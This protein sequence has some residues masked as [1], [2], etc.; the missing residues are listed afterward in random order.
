MECLLVDFLD[1]NRWSIGWGNPIISNDRLWNLN[2]FPPLIYRQH[3][4]PERFQNHFEETIENL[5]T[6]GKSIFLMRD[7][8]INL[9]H[10]SSCNYA[11]NFL[12]SLKSFN[13]I[14]TINKP[15][16][17]HNN[18]FSLIDNI[19]TNKLDGDMWPLTR[20]RTLTAS[21]FQTEIRS[22]AV[23]HPFSHIVSK[24]IVISL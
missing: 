8:N 7:T 13:L 15:P 17:V 11:Q 10:C 1:Y 12:F 6:S 16:W 23:S 2:R 14:P 4:S 24:I 22:Q 21:C 20:K 9:L 18:S 19:F 3:N 5:S